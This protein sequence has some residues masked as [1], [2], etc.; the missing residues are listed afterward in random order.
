MNGDE[1]RARGWDPDETAQRHADNKR[2]GN[3]AHFRQHNDT[4]D[5]EL[6]PNM[7]R[8]R[9]VKDLEL[10]APDWLVDGVF[11]CDT[12]ADVFGDSA[13][14]KSLLAQDI[15]CCVAT[16]T[17]WHGHAVKQGAVLYIAG[18]GQ[19]GLSRRFRA[20]E[21][22]NNVSLRH[23]PLFV[24]TVP[25]SLTDKDSQLYLLREVERF[26]AEH[27]APALIVLDTLA[28]NFGPGDENSTRDMGVAV[29][30]CDA[31]RRPTGAMVMIPHH[32]SHAEKGR[33]RGS[34][35]L[36]N[37]VDAEYGLAR[38]NDAGTINFTCTKVKD[39]VVPPPLAFRIHAVELDVRDAK[40]LPITSAVL[41]STEYQAPTRPADSAEPNGKWQIIALKILR[42]LYTEHR[43]NVAKSGRD[44][45][46]AHVE[47][48]DWMLACMDEA[49]G[50]MPR[51]RFYEV[52]RTLQSKQLI[53]I[54]G[55]HVAL[56]PDASGLSGF[57]RTGYETAETGQGEAP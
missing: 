12:T 43:A 7:L 34:I 26:T 54:T 30:A 15:S 27:G 51:N 33:A 24:S 56:L 18:E 40:G 37:G 45:D 21:L 28:R 41:V 53:A 8:F 17:P 1:P 52:K 13:T 6:P 57:D 49:N 5:D 55:P 2:A 9:H 44:P 46:C 29:S 48:K 4:E 16:G 31:L 11:E 22:H 3:G 32:S 39:D 20:W 38:G 35:A 36:H 42:D 23:A 14:G 25:T 10:K 47:T 19:S 50:C